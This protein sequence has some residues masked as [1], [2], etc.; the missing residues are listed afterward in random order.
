MENNRLNRGFMRAT[1][2]IL[3]VIGI[4]AISGFA[5]NSVYGETVI[6]VDDSG[7]AN[8]T[9]IHDAVN[10]A[11]DGDRILVYTGTYTENVNVAKKL[12]IKSESG[13]PDYTIV[14]AADPGDHVVYVMA[15]N[16]IISGL[17]LKGVIN[18]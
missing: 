11:N 8:Y 18:I 1:R 3:A 9:S 12:I 14:F 10:N 7:G 6:T 2:L 17:K 15:S 13:N 16:L 4:L 5:V